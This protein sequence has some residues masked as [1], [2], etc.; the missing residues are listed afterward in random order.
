MVK[1]DLKRELAYLYGPSPKEVALIEVPPLNYLM[2]D[3]AGDPNT[4]PEYAQALEALYSLAYTVKF[5]CK[6]QLATDFVVLPLEGL[7]W[8][9][10]MADFSV[11]R[12]GAWLWTMMIM[13]PA[14]VTEELVIAALAEVRRKKPSPALDRLR[15]EAYHEGLCVQVMHLGRYDAEG[16][17]IARL[18]AWAAEHGHALAGKHH[19]IYLGDPRRTEPARL[20]TVLRQPVRR[21]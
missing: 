8:T 15:F 11:E 16:P 13:Q 20:K 21:L 6:K 9:P 1:L 3:G 4:S 12:K 2:V 17:T 19:E 5:A 10:D 7:W 14:L 18:H